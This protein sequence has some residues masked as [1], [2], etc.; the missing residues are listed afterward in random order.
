MPLPYKANADLHCNHTHTLSS[1]GDSGVAAAAV[2]LLVV[3]AVVILS[4]R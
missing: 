1:N 3:V 4:H 2:L